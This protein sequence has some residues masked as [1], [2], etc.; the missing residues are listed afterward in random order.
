[1][2]EIATPLRVGEEE[3]PLR[4]APLRGEHTEEVLLGLCGYTVERIA[5]LADAG[6]FG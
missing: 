4:R 6:T 2:R 3:K 5:E 1:V